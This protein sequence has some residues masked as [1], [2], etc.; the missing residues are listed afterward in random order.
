MIT[1]D[2][3]AFIKKE[4]SSELP[5]WEESST[6]V[7]KEARSTPEID[8]TLYPYQKD[9]GIDI[10]LIRHAFEGMPPMKDAINEKERTQWL[11][12]W[13]EALHCTLRMVGNGNEKILKIEGTPYDYDRWIFDKAVRI[14]CELDSPDEQKAFWQ[15][16]L[17]LGSPA[18][19]W[20][21]DFLSSWFFLLFQEKNIDHD[22]FVQVWKDVLDFAFDSPKWD[23]RNFERPY[24][25]MELWRHLV[26]LDAMVIR[27][28]HD[29]KHA[30]IIKQIRNHY[31]QWAR[32][33]LVSEDSA[34]TLILFLRKPAADD[35]RLDGLLWLGDAAS[36][37]DNHFW[38]DP[39][40]KIRDSLSELLNHYW[41]NDSIRIRQSRAHWEKYKN[42]LKILVEKQNP[43]AMKLS[44]E[45]V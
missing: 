33:N 27:I 40:N 26:G 10:E 6:A 21:K 2:I 1:D 29:K 3:Q 22:I 15:P 16:V 39:E 25:V 32:L 12:F 36:Q 23:C 37:L 4:L 13:E 41:Q 9:P 42:L 43:L 7:K 20:I 24:R 45:I 17:N 44:E 8:L 31:K 38:H 28:W 5:L 19:Y 14:I 18:H 34:E 35:I 30:P 11:F